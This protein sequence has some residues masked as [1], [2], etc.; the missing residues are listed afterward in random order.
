MQKSSLYAVIPAAGKGSRLGLSG[1]KILVSVAS[2]VTIWDVL[3]EKLT[4]VVDRLLVVMSPDGAPLMEKKLAAYPIGR[5]VDIA[6]QPKP[7]GMGDAIF[8]S[9]EWWRSADNLLIVWGDQVHVSDNTL[10]ASVTDHMTMPSPCL[11]IPMVRLPKPYVEYLFDSADRLAAVRQSREGAAC[12]ENGW[13]DVGTFLLS[14]RGL[15]EAWL[16]Y[17]TSRP[18]G[19]LTGELNFLPFMVYLSQVKHWPVQRVVIENKN[20]ARGINTPEDLM[21]FQKFYGRGIHNAHDK[22]RNR[23]DS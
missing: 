1:P 2:G 18:V 11:T 22:C 9:Y 20:E 17:L 7:R 23:H 10:R 21:F 6:L 13:G 4:P 3:A 12:S 19:A 8:C 14:T 16:E 15:K 5:P